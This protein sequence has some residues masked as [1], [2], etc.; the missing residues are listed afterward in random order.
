MESLDHKWGE[1]VGHQQHASSIFKYQKFS[2]CV[3]EGGV[4]G[5]QTELHRVL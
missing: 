4:L 5:S 1:E 2:D 3:D